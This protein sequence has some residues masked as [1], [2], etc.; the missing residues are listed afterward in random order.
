ESHRATLD[1]E[2]LRGQVGPHRQLAPRGRRADVSADTARR[3][4]W[5]VHPVC[6][7]RILHA[8]NRRTPSGRL[9]ALPRERDAVRSWPLLPAVSRQAVEKNVGITR[10][11]APYGAAWRPRQW[12]RPAEDTR[13]QPGSQLWF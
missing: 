1:V 4:D 2:P 3:T 10:E 8:S 6:A 7:A 11:P 13:A 5:R 9:Q 12:R